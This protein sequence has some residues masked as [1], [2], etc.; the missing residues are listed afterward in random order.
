MIKHPVLDIPVTLALSG[1][2][3]VQN[4]ADQPPDDAMILASLC[5]APAC[6]NLGPRYARRDDECSCTVVV[7]NS[8]LIK[9]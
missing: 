8:W 2:T 6:S 7:Q 4:S 1:F 3:A 9:H 5:T